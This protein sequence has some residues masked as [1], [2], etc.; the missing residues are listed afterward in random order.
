M[1]AARGERQ[2][3]FLFLFADIRLCCQHPSP[4]VAIRPERYF[5]LNRLRGRNGAT[6]DY[7]HHQ[8]YIRQNKTKAQT[9][10]RRPTPKILGGEGEIKF[11]VFNG[12]GYSNPGTRVPEGKNAYSNPGFR[13]ENP[14]IG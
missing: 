14:G 7:F 8:R 2:E 4:I 3:K 9:S 6:A 1:K 13:P 12:S 5:P 10:R 11:L